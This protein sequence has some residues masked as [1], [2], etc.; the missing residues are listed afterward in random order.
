MN[1]LFN[2]RLYASNL[3]NSEPIPVRSL[4]IKHEDLSKLE[5]HKWYSNYDEALYKLGRLYCEKHNYDFFTDGN[6][7]IY[8]FVD[9]KKVDYKP[10]NVIEEELNYQAER[11]DCVNM[12]SLFNV[13]ILL[14]EN[15]AKELKKLFDWFGYYDTI[16]DFDT[17]KQ[18][19]ELLNIRHTIFENYLKTDN[20]SFMMTIKLV[21]KDDE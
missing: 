11:T 20:H 6:L 9:G 8:F 3:S 10:F 19:T 2:V 12:T 1:L 16:V 18:I 17:I 21:D 5:T 13:N 14:N 7:G 4:G 15:K